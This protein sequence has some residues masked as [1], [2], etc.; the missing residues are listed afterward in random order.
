MYIRAITQFD[1]FETG[2]HHY[3]VH[4]YCLEERLMRRMAQAL[5]AIWLSPTH[6]GKT[7]RAQIDSAIKYLASCSRD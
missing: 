2:L 1:H 3:S 4:K 5:P 6:Q 7:L